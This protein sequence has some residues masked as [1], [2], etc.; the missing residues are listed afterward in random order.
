MANVES[1]SSVTLSFLSFRFGGWVGGGGK[2]QGKHTPKINK[3]FIPTGPPK[4]TGKKGGKKLKKQ[5]NPRRGKKRR[6]S[7]QKTK[8]EG[9][10]EEMPKWIN[11]ALGGGCLSDPDTWRHQNRTI[12]IACD[13][14]VD[15]GKSPEIPQNE[16]VSGSETAARNRK[17]L[18]TFHRTLASQCS[19]AFSCLGDR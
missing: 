19:I 16:W 2:T 9:Q 6:K 3:N 12:A 10:K 11:W 14:R 1:L 4:I 7:Q 15:G 8:E 5:G 18:A 13:F 17:A